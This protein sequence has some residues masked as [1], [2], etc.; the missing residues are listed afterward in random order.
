MS[1][2]NNSNAKKIIAITAFVITF[3]STIVGLVQFFGVSEL[4]VIRGEYSMVDKTNS[5][6]Q[7]NLISDIAKNAGKIVYFD[8]VLIELDS[9]SEE[10][11][12][13]TGKIFF[14]L[15]TLTSYTALK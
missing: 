1:D 8:S 3:V 12:D 13:E 5:G 11:Q 7:V 4:D 15:L 14:I 9:S 6:R 10:I 2:E